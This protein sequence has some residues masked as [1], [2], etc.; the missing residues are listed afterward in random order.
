MNSNLKV[1]GFVLVDVDVA[2]LNNAGK[3][4]MSNFDK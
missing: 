4:T 3:S 2:A 1:Q